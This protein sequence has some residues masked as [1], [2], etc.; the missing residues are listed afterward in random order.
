MDVHEIRRLDMSCNFIQTLTCTALIALVGFTAGGCSSNASASQAAMS[1]GMNA[2][3]AQ[4]AAMSVP[5]VQRTQS[6][7][8]G[9][10][11]VSDEL[12]ATRQTIGDTL[13]ALQTIST[14]NGD[15][16]EPF[17]RFITLRE[18][19]EQD[20]TRIGQRAQDMRDRARDY[21][22]NWEV[23]VYGVEDKA[24]REQAEERRNR[25]REN[26][27]RISDTSRALREAFDPFRRDLKDIETF[28]ANDLTPAGVRAA[29]PSIQR[30]NQNGQEVQHRIDAV[31]AELQRVAS[32]MTPAVS[33]PT[34]NEVLDPG[35]AAPA[36]AAQGNK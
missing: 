16:L 10:R 29:S 23:E 30:A 11:A 32:A 14:A 24:L 26:Y 27:G 35:Y 25:V 7:A 12:S 20:N 31:I 5:G 36:G 28:L 3:P 13:A 17:Q 21:I 1:S 18:Q 2:A 33:Q 6:A 34:S 19:L 8:G 9:L 22:T 15:L 4:P